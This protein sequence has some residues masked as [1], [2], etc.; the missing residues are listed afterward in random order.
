MV[1]RMNE[2]P[3]I[4]VIG[5]GLGGLSAALRLAHAGARVTVL[6]AQSG[7]G[8]KMRTLPSALGPVD[9]GP[10]VL[11]MRDVFDQVFADVGARLEDHVTL[12]REDV[13]ARH[14][15]RDGSMLDLAGD[16]QADADAIGALSGARAAQE[17]RAFDAETRALLAAF[18]AP[19]M[20]AP[21]PNLGRVALNAITTPAIWRALGPRTTVARRLA[22]QFT[23]P[24]LRQ[25]FGRYATYVGGVPG[26]SPAVLSLIWQ[27][28][29]AGVW[30]VRGGMHR[31]A[32]AMA[33][34]AGDRGALFRYDTRVADIADNGRQ[35]TLDSSERLTVDATLFNGDPQA[36]ARGLL[37]W[38]P[39]HALPRRATRRR[40]LSAYV[41]TFA[42]TA[43][44]SDLAHHNVFFGD[45][46]AAEFGP[47]LRNQMPAD[48]TLYICKQDTGEHSRFEIIMNAAPTTRKPPEPT[49]GALC[50]TLVFDTLASHGLTFTPTPDPAALTTPSGFA[51]LHPG[52][53]GSLYGRSPHGLLA[54]FQR[55]T[56]R[57][58]M[59]RLYL[60]GGGTH[61]GAGVPM[62][63]LS[64]QHAAVA[65]M[66]D[67]GLT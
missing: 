11:T 43:N 62:A 32:L 42:A 57:T 46:P 18:D 40:S 63:T 19:M 37:G 50:Q 15:W 9:A 51:A 23:D 58:R 6:E 31:L 53:D 22:A 55:P 27:A 28:E 54:A 12:L 48:P 52:S 7:P 38:T 41:W 8:G 14:F 10:T 26:A 47:I 34:L 3:H 45:D 65:I 4:A 30:R 49:E 24:R 20:R 60:A 21:R 17:F 16:P 35:I 56:A 64:G 1:Q 33:Q 5:A 39:R 36:L 44:R 66:R 29:S 59:K 61:P 67:L 13:L 2:A 25:L